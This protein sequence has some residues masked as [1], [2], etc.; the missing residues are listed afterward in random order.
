LLNVD[1]SKPCDFSA[2][3]QAGQ[4]HAQVRGAIAQPFHF[5]RFRAAI[6]LTGADLSDL[7]DLTGLALPGTPPYRLQ[8]SVA[9]A[10]KTYRLTDL[11]GEL[12]NSDLSGDLTVDTG[13]AVPALSG[14]LASRRLSFDDLGALFGGGPT[15]PVKSRYL[16]PDTPLHTERLRQMNAEVD[17]TAASV[18]SR[19]FPLTSLATHIELENGVLKLS[20]LAFGFTAGK[21]SGSLKIDGSGR[22]PVTGVDARISDVHVEHFIKSADK[23]VTGVL[24]ARARL[25]GAGDSVHKAAASADGTFTLVVPHG[26]MRH[27]LAEWL[28]VD[29]ISALGLTL[30]G[31]ESNTGVRCAVAH[32]TARKGLMTARQFVFDTDPVRV[33]GRGTIDLR[34]E[35]VDLTLQ[36]KP[37][38]FQLLRLR[39]PITVKGAW[40]HPSLGVDPKPALTQ[41]GIGAALSVFNPFAA[42]LAFIDPGLTKDANCAGLLSTARSQGAPV[43]AA[44][45]KKAPARTRAHRK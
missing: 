44:P 40:A 17:Y 20:P 15:A 21:L 23:P 16:L 1:A 37:K 26:T 41:G 9:R 42:I 19:D 38:S 24:E 43:K 2:D 27:S 5:D 11:R 28:G 35:T 36:G 6:H 32:F 14:R 4:T 33:D 30:T 7:Y 25:T 18:K 8:V 22:V 10:G 39:A 3:I 34:N 29:V 13:G 31:D 45:A 12:G